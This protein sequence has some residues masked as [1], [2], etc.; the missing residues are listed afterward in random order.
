MS[1][2]KLNPAPMR[3]MHRV[4]SM[5]LLVTRVETLQ[6]SVTPKKP[7]KIKK[8]NPATDVRVR[9]SLF[10]FETLLRRSSKD[11]GVLSSS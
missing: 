7:M 2:Q 3:K 8:A 6:V 10:I 9:M 4:V 5:S 11:M 1:C